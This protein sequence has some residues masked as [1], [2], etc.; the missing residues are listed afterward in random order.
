M[1][2]HQE[3][4]ATGTFEI[5]PPIEFQNKLYSMMTLREPTIGEVIQGDGQM[6]NG[7]N[8]ESIH[9]RE[10]VIIARVSGIPLP[11]IQKIRVSTHN[12]AWAFLNNFLSR[13]LP[14]IES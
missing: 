4:D 5:N 13:G 9:N 12:A 2:D 11:V 8:M 10:C 14:T 7:P 6:R 1:S 3:T